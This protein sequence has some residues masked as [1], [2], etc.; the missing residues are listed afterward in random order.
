MKAY[1]T[2]PVM[3]L[4]PVAIPTT[5]R[6]SVQESLLTP[7]FR[8]L[9]SQPAQSCKAVEVRVAGPQATM[10]TQV[11]REVRRLVS[12]MPV[13]RED[14]KHSHPLGQHR[15]LV[16]PMPTAGVRLTPRPLTSTASTPTL[17]T[18]SSNPVILCFG[19]SLTR[20]PLKAPDDSYPAQLQELLKAAGYGHFQVVIAGHWG[21]TSATLHT[22]LT[23]A[24]AEG[25]NKGPIAFILVLGGTN[26]LLQAPIGG[27]ASAVPRAYE[28]MRIIHHAAQQVGGQPL[29]GVLTLPPLATPDLVQQA[30]K[31]N[32]LLRASPMPRQFLIDLES[33]SAA[34]L[35]D[36]VHFSRAGYGE[37]ARRA[38]QA[39]EPYLKSLPG[40][41]APTP[42]LAWGEE[43]P[44]RA[45][46]SRIPL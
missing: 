4:S 21:A 9:I 18:S 30:R 3:V 40:P 10:K 36:G 1:S 43:R 32:A 22:K 5:V 15:S 24:I 38:F 28:M 27:A 2:S 26:D 31:L 46:L 8:T 23:E 35:C 42:R 25:R 19:D 33:T 29:V 16:L 34:Y 39:L 14:T 44:R 13:L 41:L 45:L 12:N 37:F 17:V 6:T 7:R 20:G 11:G